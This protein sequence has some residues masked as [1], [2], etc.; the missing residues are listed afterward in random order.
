MASGG[1]DFLGRAA[2]LVGDLDHPFYA[3]ERQR[4]VWNEASAIGLQ[5]LLWGALG[6]ACAMTWIGGGALLPWAVALVLIVG[7]AS[8]FM[9]AYARRQGVTGLEH[10][11]LVRPRTAVAVALFGAILAGAVVRGGVAWNGS[12]SAGVAVGIVAAAGAGA[13]AAYLR[14]RSADRGDED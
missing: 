9:V 6:L 5:T 14:Q 2:R 3:E 12:D 10:V 4:E 7:A 8:G 1:Q 11:R 13:V